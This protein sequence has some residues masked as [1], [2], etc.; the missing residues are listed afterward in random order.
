MLISSYYGIWEDSFILHYLGKNINKLVRYFLSESGLIY[1]ASWSSQYVMPE[2]RLIV[3]GVLTGKILEDWYAPVLLILRRLFSVRFEVKRY[4]P[5]TTNV[6]ICDRVWCLLFVATYLCSKLNHIYCIE[7]LPTDMKTDL[8][9]KRN[10]LDTLNRFSTFIC[11]KIG[12]FSTS[13]PVS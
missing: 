2:Y 13:S 10:K 3:N 6:Y 7:M 8:L 11:G 4:R 1:C 12:I 5:R 9:Q